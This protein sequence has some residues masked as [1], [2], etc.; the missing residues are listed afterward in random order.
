MKGR[1]LLAD[2]SR[3]FLKDNK[4]YRYR[5]KKVDDMTDDEVVQNCHFYYERNNLHD[6]WLAYRE[7][8]EAEHRYCSYLQ[9]YIDEGLCTDLQMITGDY[10]KSTA[11][12]EIKID[13]EKCT[14]CCEKCIY[15]WSHN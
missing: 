13:K 14:E 1:D 11:L 4:V 8:R 7:K 9:E 10:I 2:I 3:Q 15:C 6:E 12:P 5:T